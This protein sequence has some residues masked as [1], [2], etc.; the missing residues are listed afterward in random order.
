VHKIF[1][2]RTAVATYENVLRLL[3]FLEYRTE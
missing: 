2:M 3:E 1:S